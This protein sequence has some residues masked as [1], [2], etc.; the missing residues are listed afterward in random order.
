MGSVKKSAKRKAPRAKRGSSPL[1]SQSDLGKEM[2]ATVSDHSIVFGGTYDQALRSA[3]LM[4]EHGITA[5]IMTDRAANRI[6]GFNEL[7]K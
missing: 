6:T 3:D 4:K 1:V 5:T 2:W 7:A